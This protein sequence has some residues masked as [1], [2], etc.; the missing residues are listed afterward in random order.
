[1]K[2]SEP[3]HQNE[4]T[5]NHLLLGATILAALSMVLAAVMPLA[6]VRLPEGTDADID[7]HFYVTTTSLVQ[8]FPLFSIALILAAVVGVFAAVR[9]IRDAKSRRGVTFALIFA[10]AIMSWV[11]VAGMVQADAC[12]WRSD[13]D[14]GSDVEC[15]HGTDYFASGNGGWRFAPIRARLSDKLTREYRAR[16][17]GSTTTISVAGAPYGMRM[18]G[19]WLWMLFASMSLVFVIG[20]YCVWRAR[21]APTR[22][23]VASVLSTVAW[24]FSVLV[25]AVYAI[26]SLN[27]L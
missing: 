18:I 10:A 8:D 14:E 12:D 26:F 13:Q 22:A 3:A 16:H 1:M 20:V 24:A 5:R 4:R 2:D 21:F 25:V 19:P 6:E 11:A 15:F 17:P 7:A 23:T 27:P 9:M